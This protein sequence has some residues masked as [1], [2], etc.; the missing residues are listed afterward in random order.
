MSSI[1][2]EINATSFDELVREL[3]GAVKLIV[4]QIVQ[5]PA[6]QPP[7]EAGEPV[8]AEVVDPPRKPRGGRRPAPSIE[9]TVNPPADAG[10]SPAVGSPATPEATAPVEGETADQPST[11]TP[12]DE[13][14]LDYQKDVQQTLIAYVNKEVALRAAKK[15]KGADRPTVLNEVRDRFKITTKMFE[16]SQPVLRDILAW[17]NAEMP[18]VD[19]AQAEIDAAAALEG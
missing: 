19:A 3:G 6:S 4:P 16:V 14:P 9:A 1:R 2:L 15:E 13:K 18:R 8:T 10:T 7:A 11:G 17:L 12:S 5:V